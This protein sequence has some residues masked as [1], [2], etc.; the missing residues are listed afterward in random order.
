MENAFI[1][2]AFNS[3]GEILSLF[4]KENRRENI[5]K[6]QKGNTLRFFEDRPLD[7]DA[8]DI[9]IFYEKKP[10]EFEVSSSI[11]V[12]E[13]G[14]LRTAIEVTQ[15]VHNSSITQRI[16]LGISS[17]KLEFETACNWNESH[18]LLKAFFP[19]TILSPKI[20]CEIQWGNVE[21]PTHRNT[22]WDEA[23]FEIS[24]HKW[25]DISEGNYG[26][27][28]L[29]DCKYGHSVIENTISL[30][31]LR[32][33]TFP[34]KYA[35]RGN[36]LFTYSILPHSGDWR[37][38]TAKEAYSLNNP[39]IVHKVE[40]NKKSSSFSNKIKS[41]EDSFISTSYDG[42]IIETV[43]LSEKSQELVV[44]LY[45]YKRTRKDDVIITLPK[46]TKNAYLSN[47]LERDQHHIKSLES[48]NTIIMKQNKAHISVNPYQILTLKASI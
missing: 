41:S 28:L 39:C 18:L 21:R 42:T 33:P 17:R 31:L 7:W 19:T 5:P 34:D 44:R 27:S 25:I 1:K 2:A 12:I 9:D 30:T 16:Y 22:S 23:K 48:E 32:S 35:D 15:K 38:I 36:H 11:T 6:G 3:A 40:Q 37:E 4:D 29:N 20:T 14:P 13:E 24:A 10:L 8:W 26:I 47:I 43:K 45:E 46:T